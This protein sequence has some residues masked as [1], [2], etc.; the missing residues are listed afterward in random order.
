MGTVLQNIRFSLRMLAKSPGLTIT[1]LLTIALGIGANTA[2][3]TVDYATLLAPLPYPDPQQLVMLWSTIQDHNTL[4]ST[5]EFIDWKN[6]ST[7]FESMSAW[8]ESPM[9]IATRDQPELIDVTK[10][11]PGFFRMMGDQFY[12]GRDVL[13]EEGVAGKDHVAILTHKLWEHL[14][15]NEHILGTAIRLDDEPYTVIGV[16]APGLDDRGESQLTIP[17]AFKPEQLNHD[18][19]WLY[20]MGRMRPGVTL[21]QAQSNLDTVARDISL[22]YP[23]SNRGRSAKVEPLKN[24][25]L[26]SDRILTLWLLLGAVGFILLIACVN[27]ANLL[28]SKSLGRHK[29]MAV[30]SALGAQRKTIFAQLITESLLLALG[31]GILGVLVGFGMLKGLIAA[32]PEGTLPVEADLSLN[33]PILLFSLAATTLAGLLFGCAPAWIASRIDPAETLKEGGRTG[34]GKGRHLLRR[35]LVIGEF[36]LA[37]ALLAGAG[38]AIHSFINL[39]RVDL[40]LSTDHVLTFSMP[41]PESRPKDPQQIIAYYRRV[42]DNIQ[43][44]AGVEHA[45]AMMSLPLNGSGLVVPFTIVGKPASNDPSQR[46]SAGLGLVTPDYFKTFGI[47]LVRGREFNSEDTSS[48]VK[49]MMIN[50]EVANRFF[51]GT[52]PL[53]QRISMKQLIPGVDNFGP[54][55]EWQI[56]GI[57]HTVRSRGFRKDT[58]EMLTS[59]WQ[60]PWPTAAIGVRTAGDPAAMIKS[61]AAAVHAVD[62]QVALAETKTMEEVRDDVLAN[63]RFTVVLFGC[64]ATVALLLAGLGIYGVMSFSVTQRSHEIALRMALGAGRN[65]VVAQVLREGLTL[66]GIGLAIGLVGAYFI[67]RAM[68]TILFGVGSLDF[69]AFSVVAVILLAASLVACFLPARRA[70]SVEPMQVLRSE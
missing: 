70:A 49:T 7:A 27:V 43:A 65:R 10:T 57:Y 50:E 56:I 40:G 2:I 67:G 29:E 39:Q 13:P 45:S 33:V 26:P 53:T 64:F 28:V 25:F 66:A 18:F 23:K 48:S 15:G 22:T 30:R 41:V 44:V 12:L 37:L 59:F 38:L 60:L 19:H 9:N 55:A 6:Q 1:V 24:D 5:G 20:A 16:L 62:P 47:R 51:K 8:T 31:G 35:S 14:G 52:D 32:M 11:T 68:Q 3:F 36:A 34:S 46:V 69:A 17:L 54:E 21:K 42:L 4:V 63:D 58:P 61:V